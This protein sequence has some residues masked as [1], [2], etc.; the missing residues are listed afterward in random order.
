[1]ESLI[2]LGIPVKTNALRVT[3]REASMP[4]KGVDLA[5][6]RAP[7]YQ[8]QAA[9]VLDITHTNHY[10]AVSGLKTART[11]YLTTSDISIFCKVPDDVLLF[12]VHES[13]M[14][15][16]GGRRVALG[17]GLSR[18]TIDATNNPPPFAHRQRRA[19][20]NFRATLNQ[21]LC[22]IL[23]LALVPAL[24]ARIQVDRTDY[25]GGDYLAALLN[26]QL[27]LA[28]GGDFFR[29]CRPIHTWRRLSPKSLIHIV[30]ST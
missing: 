27:C 13:R 28:Y 19:P 2:E 23:D 24:E 3:S 21:G 7:M 14:A 12:A 22:G 29:R 18:R 9:Y 26:S 15:R 10:S 8:G 25:V 4:L 20:R 5:S 30:S 16:M 6:L 11:A 17:F 1:M